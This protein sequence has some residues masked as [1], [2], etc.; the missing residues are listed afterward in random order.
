[1]SSN[2]KIRLYIIY[3]V[4]LAFTSNCSHRDSGRDNVITTATLNGPSAISM[5]Y[6][7]EEEPVLEGKYKTRFSIKS[8]PEQVKAL[9]LEEK[10]DFAV[11]PST[12]GAILYNLTGKYILAAIPVW[13]TLYLCG[14]DSSI[15]E[16]EDLKGRE[17]YLMGKGMTPD[18]M[19]RYLAEKHG[20]VPDR[21]FSLN[22]SFNGH[23]ELANAL[24]AGI[25]EL[26]V[27]SEPMVSLIMSRNPDVK[28]LLSFDRS[29]EE[30]QHGKIPLAQ[31]AL[32]VRRDLAENNP[33]MVSEY[34]V[35]LENSIN[36][37]NANH[38]EA[39]ELIV[40]HGIL[41]EKE[42]AERAIPLSSLKFSYA[43][44]EMKGINEYFKVFYNFNPLITGGKLPDEGF[45][46]KK[47]DI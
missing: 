14:T 35:Y 24:S 36:R 29:W 28:P 5:I 25:A 32:L 43:G 11:L 40:K 1:M 34:L 37:A 16:W 22:Y 42:L 15:E 21:D 45:Y 31:T 19:F 10:V 20:L 44:K 41:P 38:G 33:G 8:E 12:M 46:F 2:K 4:A 27:I 18:V 13:G 39:A 9:M 26:G 23:I 3:L 6:M 17:I 47:A 30:V 7:I